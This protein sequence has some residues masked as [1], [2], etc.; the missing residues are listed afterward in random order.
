MQSM[1]DE[2]NRWLGIVTDEFAAASGVFPVRRLAEGIGASL[3][4]AAVALS[5]ALPS[6]GAGARAWP[7]IVPPD[8]INDFVTSASLFRDPLVDWFDHTQD[9]AP[10]SSARVPPG[11]GDRADFARWRDLMKG[12]GI[13]Q[14][15][16]VPLYLGP[17]CHLVFV[18]VRAGE[19][20]SDQEVLLA[21]RIQ[22]A[23]TVL[24]RQSEVLARHP[25]AAT[26][27]ADG[28]LTGREM[29][30]LV[31]LEQG[32]TAVAI[33]HQLGI[34]ERTV[35]KH[36]ERIYRKMHVQD[37]LSAIVQAQ[38]RGWLPAPR[39]PVGAAATQLY[40]WPPRP[41]LPHDAGGSG[42][43]GSAAFGAGRSRALR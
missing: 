17:R 31:L 42:V 3:D 1:E 26:V 5:W 37:R 15:L 18:A 28:E 36:L 12:F 16:G 8:V 32:L 43:M 21:K 22:P 13:E 14:R 35:H 34:A 10:Q 23:L 27:V 7:P 24:H 33:G 6:Q 20:F 19:D 40:V 2:L 4:A 30:V 25:D 29:S 9:V 41:E 39:H 11:F 38:Q